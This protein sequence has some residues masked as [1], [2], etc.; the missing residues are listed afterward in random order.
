MA[1]ML[2]GFGPALSAQSADSGASNEAQTPSGTEAAT[3]TVIDV[4][5]MAAEPESPLD[6]AESIANEPSPNTAATDAGEAAEAE[7]MLQ[8]DRIEAK[9]TYEALIREE[10]YHEAIAVAGQ[11]LEMTEQELGRASFELVPILNDLGLTLIEAGQPE[12]SL[13]HFERSVKL[14]EDHHGIFSSDL[15]TPLQGTGLALQKLG[16]HAGAVNHFH[17][18]QHVT[19]RNEG[20]GNFSQLPIM[21]MVSE[22]LE[23]QQL[24]SDAERVQRG[25]LKINRMKWGEDSLQMVDPLKDLSEWYYRFADFNQARFT[26]RKA[27]EIQLGHLHPDVE[28]MRSLLHEM[29]LDYFDKFGGYWLNGRRL[30]DRILSKTLIHNGTTDAHRAYAFVAMGDFFIQV[31]KSRNAATAYQKA[32]QLAQA[33]NIDFASMDVDL[34]KPEQLHFG[35]SLVFNENAIESG[36]GEPYCEFNFSVGSDGRP[37]RIKVIECNLKPNVQ[38]FAI[39]NFNRAR[40]RPMIEDGTPVTRDNVHVRRVYVP[41]ELINSKLDQAIPARPIEQE[42]V[43]PV[44]EPTP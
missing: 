32:W 17:R 33:Y 14:V 29:A 44:K 35:P 1:F 6:T 9:A 34:S 37:R 8:M 16:N 27:A 12:A 28:D 23:A 26:Y 18:A 42:A 25:M 19:H 5:G 15:V 7:L 2:T 38:R 4:D 22:S 20:V 41:R 36:T 43:V 21:Q 3:E 31:D 39:Q 11:T 10:K 24:Y 30:N 40:F 13:Q